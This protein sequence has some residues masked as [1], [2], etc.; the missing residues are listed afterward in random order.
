MAAIVGS[1]SVSVAAGPD[2]PFII[3]G[4]QLAVGGKET[5]LRADRHCGAVDGTRSWPGTTLGNSKEDEDV[6]L[7]RSSSDAAQLRAIQFDGRIMVSSIRFLL[8]SIVESRP[9]GAADPEWIAGQKRLGESNDL[10]TGVGRL[11]HPT[12]HAMS[13]RF[14]V[15][16][17]RGILDRRNSEQRHPPWSR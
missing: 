12:D 1:Q 10:G 16:E 11:F 7:G 4:D 9:V 6:Q 5:A 14:P 15:K 2:K 3:R 13:S 17:H 8:T